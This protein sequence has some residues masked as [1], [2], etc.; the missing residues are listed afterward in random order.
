MEQ[1]EV[2]MLARM[3]N[4]N[5]PYSL[6]Y[7]MQLSQ[8]FGVKHFGCKVDW[9]CH[10][11]I[12]TLLFPINPGSITLSW[13]SG[14]CVPMKKERRKMPSGMCYASAGGWQHQP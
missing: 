14:L 3:K 2:E 7:M 13:W 9:V 10:E 6:V 11:S 8:K 4:P 12:T 5:I 1:N